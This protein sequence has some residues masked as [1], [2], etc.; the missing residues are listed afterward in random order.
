MWCCASIFS[1]SRC[2]DENWRRSV[3][4]L[5]ILCSS[6]E[7][8]I[9]RNSN[10]VA[11][12]WFRVSSHLFFFKLELSPFCDLFRTKLISQSQVPERAASCL[13]CL[14]FGLHF[15]I[16]T[17]PS[18]FCLKPLWFVAMVVSESFFHQLTFLTANRCISLFEAQ[19]F[20]LGHFS[21]IFSVWY[22][23]AF[24]LFYGPKEQG[25]CVVL[26]TWWA[27]ECLALWFQGQLQ[28]G[29]FSFSFFLPYYLPVSGFFCFYLCILS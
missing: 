19:I 9:F 21:C 11:S 16:S 6:S 3:C 27:D 17:V 4:C 2:L 8:L 14:Q 20:S 18:H 24:L 28:F 7:K 23:F 12:T 1:L 15:S 26:M 22:C 25:G 29:P 13:N 10:S 5:C